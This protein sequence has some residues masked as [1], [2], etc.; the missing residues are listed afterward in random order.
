VKN[1]DL[2]GTNGNSIA[3]LGSNGYFLA[4]GVIW[5]YG[6]A[7]ALQDGLAGKTPNT[8]YWDYGNGSG[9]ATGSA[10][11]IATNAYS[12]QIV[13][14]WLN[15]PLADSYFTSY[16]L[17]PPIKPSLAKASG[18]LDAAFLDGY[19][20]LT[21]PNEGGGSDFGDHVTTVDNLS[22][23]VEIELTTQLLRNWNVT[24]NYSH[25][26]ATHSGH[27]PGCPGLHQPADRVHERPR[28]TDPHV[29]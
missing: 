24:L 29:V 12:Q 25:V 20:D 21:A 15:I 16:N 9:Y 1:A 13:N 18:Q 22:K 17:S 27:R 6:W 11:Y 23:G 28:R 4:D 19:N 2:N 5:G 7:A 14:A 8:N 26:N 3:G 10:Q